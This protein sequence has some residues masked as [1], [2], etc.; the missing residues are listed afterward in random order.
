[1]QVRWGRSAP[2]FAVRRTASYAMLHRQGRRWNAGMQVQL[3]SDYVLCS[4]VNHVNYLQ[5]ARIQLAHALVALLVE[6]CLGFDS[7]S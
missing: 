5:C 6:R 4:P 1:M 2:I 7:P 3:P